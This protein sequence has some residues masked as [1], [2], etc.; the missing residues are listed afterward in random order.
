MKKWCAMLWMLLFLTACGGQ[1]SEI[2]LPEPPVLEQPPRLTAET[3]AG[4]VQVC[5][6]TASWTVTDETGQA[7]GFE[8]DAVHPLDEQAVLPVLQPGDGTVTLFFDGTAPGKIDVRCWDIEQR[9]N[10]EAVPELFAVEGSSFPLKEGSYIYE[11]RGWWAEDARYGGSAFYVF[12]VRDL[13]ITLAAEQ[14]TE[15]GLTLACTQSGGNPTGELNTGSWYELQRMGEKGW[16]QVPYS[17]QLP[18]DAD[19]AWT[20]E[21][22]L[23][24]L[25]DTVQWD[26]TLDYLYG[27]LQPGTYRILKEIMDFRGPGDFDQGI[28]YAV[29]TIPET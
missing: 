5:Y 4:L 21:A 23:I 2:T 6:G 1:S 22:W 19:V 3:S 24:P 18:T 27:K 7:T 15:E 8:A 13:G 25:E 12:A 17:D 29:F 20:A 16:E 26:I 14:V 11:V 10:V 28:C 9:G